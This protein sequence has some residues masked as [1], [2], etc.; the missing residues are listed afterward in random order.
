V[1]RLELPHP[2]RP[3]RLSTS[4]QLQGLEGHDREPACTGDDLGHGDLHPI[5][6]NQELGARHLDIGMVLT[7]TMRLEDKLGLTV[8]TTDH[9]VGSLGHVEYEV[10]E[11]VSVGTDTD[12]ALGKALVE[13]SNYHHAILTAVRIRQPWSSVAGSRAWRGTSRSEHADA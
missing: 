9:D 1:I 2:H 6:A 11:T 4:T 5:P 13:L 3:R 10:P 8:R 12:D 7:E